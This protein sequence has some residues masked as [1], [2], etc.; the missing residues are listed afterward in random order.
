MED[1]EAD[2]GGTEGVHE[3]EVVVNVVCSIGS[4]RDGNHESAQGEE[5]RDEA[6]PGRNSSHV[7]RQEG[8]Q[9]C[10]GGWLT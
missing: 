7:V 4:T 6:E 8:P 3:D 9:G 10:D 2:G 1:Q 5:G